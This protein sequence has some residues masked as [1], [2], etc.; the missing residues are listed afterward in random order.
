MTIE[1]FHARLASEDDSPLMAALRRLTE[2]KKPE[3]IVQAV[4]EALVWGWRAPTPS[5]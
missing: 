5:A 4:P 1:A 3:D 2:I